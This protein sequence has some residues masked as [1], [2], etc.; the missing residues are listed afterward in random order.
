MPLQA[1]IFDVDATLAETERDGRPL[2]PG[3]DSL[4]NEAR[5][6]GIRLAIATTTSPDNVTALLRA[7]LAPACRPW[8]QRRNTPK[9]RTSAARSPCCRV[10]PASA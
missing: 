9:A 8:S 10:W 4:L 6:A 3:V 1:L 7:S 5:S 2:R